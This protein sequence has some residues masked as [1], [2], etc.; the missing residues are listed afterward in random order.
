MLG[1]EILFLF[2]ILIIFS[3]ISSVHADENSSLILLETNKS[4][5]YTGDK[6]TISGTILEKKM[7]VIA[8]RIYDPDGIILSANNVEINEDGT[9]SRSIFLDAPFY[10]KKGT[11]NVL[12]DYGKE[13]SEI[14]FIIF[15]EN[16]S[17]SEIFEEIFVE[18]EIIVLV[19]DKDEYLDGE[20]VV[21]N[22]LASS[23][24]MVS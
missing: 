21:I 9:F 24:F 17:E 7:P 13:T 16:F 1:K 12:F 14:K 4:Q 2:S 23:D 15:D 6:L 20:Y 18:P 22:G 5:F 11:Y 3:G 8:M 10:E 19:T